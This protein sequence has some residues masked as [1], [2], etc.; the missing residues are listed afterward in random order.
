MNPTCLFV[1]AFSSMVLEG[2]WYQIE[3]FLF[4]NFLETFYTNS[5]KKMHLSSYLNTNT[6][7]YEFFFN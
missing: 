6:V 1:F 4:H 5:K 7:R 3:I 2:K